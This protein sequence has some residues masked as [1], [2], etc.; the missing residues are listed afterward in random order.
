[1]RW[2]RRSRPLVTAIIPTFNWSTVLACS[3]RSVLDQTFED[4]ELL[5]IG[6]ACSDDSGDVVASFAAADRRV[7]WMNLAR[8][9]GSQSGPNNEGLRHARGEFIAYL[10]HD[11]LWLPRHLEL[12]LAAL[13]VRAA[14]PEHGAYPNG[15][16]MAHGRVVQV[17]PGY[18]PFLYPHVSWKYEKGDWIPPTST[19]HRARAVREAG[20]WRTPATTGMLDPEADLCARIARSTGSPR[21]VPTVTSV[22]LPAAYRK[23][24]YRARPSGEQRAWLGRIRSATDPEAALLALCCEPGTRSAVEDDAVT[25]LECASVSAEERCRVRRRFKGLEP[26]EE[27]QRRQA[28][29]K[30]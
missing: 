21:L 14:R 24:V 3:I 12:L 13:T 16:G 4:F 5:V 27:I 26:P 29:A 23:D 1:M 15:V 18:E 9:V 7:R 30:K 22:K 2:T 28:N 17:N 20:G 25:M 19:M 6:D 8:H 11:D 10:G